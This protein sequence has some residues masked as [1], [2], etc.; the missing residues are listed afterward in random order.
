MRFLSQLLI[1]FLLA[2]GCSKNSEQNNEA[3]LSQ[4]N[5]KSNVSEQ[6]KLVAPMENESSEPAADPSRVITPNQ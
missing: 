2:S 4:T 5:Q 6:S 1:V 3:D